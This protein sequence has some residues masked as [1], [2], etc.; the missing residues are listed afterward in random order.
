[1]YGYQ[2]NKAGRWRNWEI[3]IGIY[4]L[5]IY[6]KK[7]WSQ[8]RSVVSDSLQPHWLY[9]PWNSPG[10]NTGVASLSLLLGIF[11]TQGWNPGLPHCRQILYHLSHQGSPL[12][13]QPSNFQTS[14]SPPFLSPS[15]TSFPSPLPPLSFHEEWNLE[16]HL[17]QSG[18][19][20][21]SASSHQHKIICPIL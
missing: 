6:M 3:W 20:S 9:S 18:I 5:L 16:P 13:H 7:K 21:M 2:G 17:E 14:T 19:D 15:P 1:M 8:S 4:T 11:P 10:Q 12:P